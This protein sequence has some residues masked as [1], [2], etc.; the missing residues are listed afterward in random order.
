M[1]HLR[2]WLLRFTGLFF[3]DARERELAA[4][5][6]T[7]LQMHIDDNIRAGMSPQ[8][9]SRVAVMK[10]G[11]VEQTK[12]A[13]RDRA[14][15]PFLESVV[16]D[17]R[18]TLRQL[19]KNPAFTV[20]ATAMV[21]LGIGASVAIFAFVDAALIKPLPYQNPSRLLFVTET[22][23]DIPRAVLSYPDYLDW[24]NLNRVFDSMDVYTQRGYV[25]STT[26]GVEMVDGA[27]V[28]DGFFRTL[29][30][31]PLL[32]RDFYR[33]EDLPDAPRTVVLSYASWQ[34][35]FGGRQDIV[36]QPIT[37]N[38]LPHT[39][40]GVLPQ[41][42]H[43]APVEQAEFWTTL[44][45]AGTCDL[46]RSC[47]FL[48]GI[49]RLIDGVSQEAALAD[50]TRIAKDLEAQYPDS[51]RN[52]GATVGPLAEVIVGDVKPTLLLLLG[53][54]GLL[55]LIA[56]INVASL[57]LVRSETRRRELAVRRALGATSARL[58]RQ[59]VIEGLVIVAVGATAGLLGSHWMMQILSGLIPKDMMAGMPYLE[60]LGLS[61]RVLMFALGIAGFA[62]VLFT[63]T[64]ALRL[65]TLDV[66]DG[67]AEGARGTAGR[68]WRRIG[69]KLV[70][71][72]LT[73][74][75]VLLVGAG[76]LG[77]SF[78]RLLQVGAGFETKR[79]ITMRVRAPRS[80]YGEDEQAVALGRN[81]V[82]DVRSLP[83]VTSVALVSTL[84]LTFNGN[85]EW[86]RF[87]GRAYNGEHNEVNQRGISSDYFATL[88]AKLLRGRTFTDSEDGT[89]PK[90]VV[91]NQTLAKKYF[92]N[93]DPIGQRFGNTDLNPA[94]IKEIIGVVDDIR[95]GPLDSEIWPAYYYAFNQVPD[96]AFSVVVRTSQGEQSLI[97]TVAETVRRID[98]RIT[99]SNQTTMT[100]RVNDAP[101][102]YLR[103]SS[104][105]LVGG[106]AAVA[107]LLGV[108]GLYGVI[109]Y[110]V[111]QRTRE[112]GVRIALGAQRGMVYRLILKE[113]GVLA[114]AGIVI[115]TGCA[116]LAASLM[117]KLLFGTPPWDVATL[118]SVAAVL[119]ASALLASFLPARRAASVDPM[120]AL[121]AE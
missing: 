79:L 4:E 21:A 16:Q 2:A 13:Y 11:G 71:L 56:C 8:E 75:M 39:I 33:G 97:P 52:Q 9:A 67:I 60:D 78:Y 96:F 57:L 112:I 43:F 99:I 49:G 34:K 80:A 29:G 106:F 61:S 81:V 55:L 92:P 41:N 113:A 14:T 114:L 87:V 95:E 70:I 15:I 94:S 120:S 76:L 72:E 44:H 101:T 91:I 48:N 6:E 32:G 54:A 17:L 110:S 63:V 50:V 104:T 68:V 23:P 115:G 62:S 93:E 51:N 37:L 117:R 45:P 5:L 46:R 36:G 59:F 107:L 121:R 118:I 18:F 30:V 116:I 53:G 28:S 31:G 85:T 24:K 10:L 89:K 65:S 108:V 86:I 66:R 19:R 7:H 40:V 74:A 47:H 105:W 73:T 3:K 27:R 109:A 22:T 1:R 64:P 88:Q 90:V 98:S 42:F 12:E 82:N 83:G 84:P 69:S 58:V 26:G 111:S 100:A 119:S 38:E 77:K 20:T 25:I 102:V 103:R 35:R